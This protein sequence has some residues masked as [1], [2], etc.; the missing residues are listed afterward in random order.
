MRRLLLLLLVWLASPAQALPLDPWNTWA[1]NQ[2][3]VSRQINPH[4][5]V[6]RGIGTNA[7]YVIEVDPVTG[8]IPVSATFTSTD[9]HNYGTVGAS[10]LRSAAQIGNA[11]GAADFNHGAVGAQTLRTVSVLSNGTTGASFGAGATGTTTLR[12][13]LATDQ[14]SI[15]VTE[16]GTWNITNVSGTVT[17]PTGAATAA[18]QPALGTAG[19]PSTDVISIQGVAGGTALPVSAASLPLPAGAATETT[20]AAV[21]T[22]L[23]SS[24]PLPTGAATET[25]LAALSAKHPATLG[26]KTMSASLAVAIASDQSS[27]PVTNFPTTVDTNT[28]AAGASTIRTVLSTRQEAAATPIAVRISDGS[29]FSAPSQAG[30]GYSDSVRLTYSGTNVTTGAWVQLIASTAAVINAI[31]LFDSCGQ[32]LELGTGA[33]ASETRKLIIPPGGIGG[34]IPLAIPAST[35]LSVRAVSATCSSGELDITGL[36]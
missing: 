3:Y 18:K 19:T 5:L 20:L 2:P 23:G 11:T 28:G 31:T 36:N 6:A 1:T 14:S 30:R 26:Q 33:A 8:A 27:I 4:A 34:I 10:T 9:D 35:R 21:N 29:N 32:T 17:L 7:Y 22:K 15:P 16:S 13:V 12:A 25:T 24:L